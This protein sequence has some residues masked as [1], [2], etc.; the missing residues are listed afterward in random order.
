[1]PANG[2]LEAMMSRATPAKIGR[3]GPKD[4]MDP[5]LRR[6]VE[7]AEREDGIRH[8]GQMM[9]GRP[10]FVDVSFYPARKWWV[11][12]SNGDRLPMTDDLKGAIRP[13]LL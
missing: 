10:V 4:T 9:D 7:R 1:M 6:M 5:E 11:Y 13:L 3:N 2:A 12:L 8:G